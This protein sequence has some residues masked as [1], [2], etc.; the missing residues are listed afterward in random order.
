M[1]S[2]LP[3]SLLAGSSSR[4]R[5]GSGGSGSSSSSGSVRSCSSGC[6]CGS[7]SGCGS[8]GRCRLFFFTASSQGSGSDHG[9]QNEGL[10]H[11]NLPFELTKN[12]RKLSLRPGRK[13]QAK[14]TRAVLPSPKLYYKTLRFLRPADSA[15]WPGL[16]NRAW[17]QQSRAGCHAARSPCFPE[18]PSSADGP[19]HRRQHSPPDQC[20]AKTS[21]GSRVRWAARLRRASG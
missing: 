20:D 15:S 8:W 11:M 21:A 7:S 14:R 2:L 19:H 4:C 6:R 9:G 12:F 10:V 5:S 17:W 3:G 1:N 18:A 16:T 13:D